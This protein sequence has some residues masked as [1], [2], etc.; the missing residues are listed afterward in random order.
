MKKLGYINNFII[1]KFTLDID[2]NTPILI[3]DSNIEHMK[4]THPKDYESYKDKIIDIINTPD[5]VGYRTSDK[6]IEYI[7]EFLINK[8]Y[9]K[10]AV[11]VTTKGNFFVRTLYTLNKNKVKRYI[12]KGNIIKFLTK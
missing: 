2:E 10:V 12:E 7:K 11:R 4:N 1:N 5:Y 6:S 3:G 9:V 8:E